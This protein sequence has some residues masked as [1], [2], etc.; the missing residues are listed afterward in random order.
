[1]LA[2]GLARS[3]MIAIAAHGLPSRPRA[4]R[5]TVSGRRRGCRRR[6]RITRGDRAL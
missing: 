1:M 6:R 3:V 2:P 4:A 5:F